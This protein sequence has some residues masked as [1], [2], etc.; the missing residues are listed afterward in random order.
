MN[1][2]RA[3]IKQQ[4]NPISLSP[5]LEHLAESIAKST[6]IP[7]EFRGNAANCLI[8]LEMA[9]RIGAGVL[10]VMQSLYIVHGKPSWSGQFII[11]AVNST[12]RFSPLEFA[13]NAD[14]TECFAFATNH[15][16]NI[17]KGPTVSVDMAKKEGWYDRNPKWKNMT[18]LMLMYRAGTFFGRV[19]CS[20]ILMGM[21]EQYEILE[22]EAVEIKEPQIPTHTKDM[23]HEVTDGVEG[24]GIA[25]EPV[26]IEQP[27]VSPSQPPAPPSPP[28]KTASKK[29]LQVKPK[30]PSVTSPSKPQPNRE[31]LNARLMV[32]GFSEAQFLAIANENEW[33]GKGRKW[34][35]LDHLNN[36]DML[37]VFLSDEEWS[38]VQSELE[39]AA[40]ATSSN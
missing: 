10:Q 39:Q 37:A 25:A 21:R 36:D 4:D 17:I 33:L 35:S 38:V 14:K 28:K 26:T 1:S 23:L 40:N 5:A 2:E 15:D 27:A 29:K 20:D 22:A 8:A 34:D 32:G 30:A 6:L 16:G 18:E 9:H 13:M 12:R 3:I 7:Q 31:A 24:G 11:G 19:Y